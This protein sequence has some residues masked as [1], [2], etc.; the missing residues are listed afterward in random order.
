[1]VRIGAGRGELWKIVATEFGFDWRC[2][3]RKFH[4]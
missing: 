2:L 4:P 3:P 1:M